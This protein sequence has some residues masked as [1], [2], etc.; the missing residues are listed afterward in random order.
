MTSLKIA[1]PKFKSTQAINPDLYSNITQST[2]PSSVILPE[3][4]NKQT[5]PISPNPVDTLEPNSNNLKFYNLEHQPFANYKQLFNKPQN[6]NVI[7]EYT[8]NNDNLHMQSINHVLDCE[9]CKQILLKQFNI[10]TQRRRTQDVLEVFTFAIFC[11]FILLLL[12]K[13]N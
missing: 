9:S 6:S 4:T 11:I 5:I 3:P 10:E 13:L 7:E 1:F 8:N 12:D 2:M